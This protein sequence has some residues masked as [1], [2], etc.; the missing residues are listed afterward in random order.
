MKRFQKAN[1]IH[2]SALHDVVMWFFMEPSIKCRKY[3]FRWPSCSG[4]L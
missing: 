1:A 2:R 3:P 4:K